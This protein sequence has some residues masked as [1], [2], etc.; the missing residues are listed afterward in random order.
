[1]NVWSWKDSQLMTS[2]WNRFLSF[3]WFSRLASWCNMNI[4]CHAICRPYMFLTKR[5]ISPNID[6]VR[7]VDDKVALISV[8][9][10]KRYDLLNVVSVPTEQSQIYM[11]YITTYPPSGAH[12]FNAAW[13]MLHTLWSRIHVLRKRPQDIA[14]SPLPRCTVMASRSTDTQPLPH[15]RDYPQANLVLKGPVRDSHHPTGG[16]LHSYLFVGAS[17][18]KSK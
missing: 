1:M 15:D 14:R 13:T 4:W 11:T 16:Y 8:V 2:N 6:S 18:Q 3:F 9:S 7:I 10:S 17:L 5:K 12:A